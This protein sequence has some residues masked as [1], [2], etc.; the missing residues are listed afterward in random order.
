[1]SIHRRFG[2]LLALGT[3]AAVLPVPTAAASTCTA[4]AAAPCA[5][6]CLEGAPITVSATGTGAVTGWCSTAVAECVV[7]SGACSLA[8]AGL[9]ASSGTGQCVFAG[10]G[11]GTC[12]APTAAQGTGLCTSGDAPSLGVVTLAT[13]AGTY[14]V[15]D[16][17]YLL[18]NGLWIYVE[19]NLHPGLQR[20]GQSFVIPDDVETCDD[21]D[22]PPD[23]LV[24]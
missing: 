18:G 22:S 12:T 20:G 16:R 2:I 14:Y 5:F 3:L 23:Q 11:S 21:G 17:N 15:D 19:T 4:T 6:S 1:M 24:F 13:P 7:Q 10:E 9:A 8:S